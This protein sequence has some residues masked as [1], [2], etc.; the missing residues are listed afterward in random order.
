M[1]NKESHQSEAFTEWPNWVALR[2]E[3]YRF[4]PNDQL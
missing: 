3:L 2:A 1:I 4:L